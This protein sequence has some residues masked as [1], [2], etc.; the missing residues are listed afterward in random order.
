VSDNP[1]PRL[2]RL[3]GYAALEKFDLNL[4]K[5]AFV[6]CQDYNAIQFIKNISNVAD[7]NMKKAQLL[8]YLNKFDEAENVYT[9]TDNHEMALEMRIKLGDWFKVMAMIEDKEFSTS[10]RLDEY[11]AKAR[12]SIGEYFFEKQRYTQALSYFNLKQILYNEI[13]IDAIS[14]EEIKYIIECLYNS[15]KYKELYDL[16]KL[17]PAASK[18]EDFLHVIGRKLITVGL[19]E[20]GVD[21]LVRSG[22]IREAIDACVYLNE[23]EQAMKLA[24][25]Q[26]LSDEILSFFEKY[27]KHLVESQKYIEAI[28]LYRRANLSTKSAEYLY[29][30]ARE[31]TQEGKQPLLSKKLYVLA[32]IEQQKQK[33]LTEDCWSGAEAYHLFVLAQKQLYYGDYQKSARNS[34]RLYDYLNIIPSK[35]VYA[36]V[37]LTCYYGH[38]YVGCSEAISRLQ[39]GTEATWCRSQQLFETSSPLEEIAIKIF[40]KHEPDSTSNT[41]ESTLLCKQCDSLMKEQDRQCNKCLYVYHICMATGDTILSSNP[42]KEAHKCEQCNHY[43]LIQEYEKRKSCPLCYNSY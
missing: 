10:K 2:W 38:R 34:L 19:C 32:A 35:Q 6:K 17:L 18:Y 24:K 15:E 4:A 37:A 31:S 28:E 22:H 8:T 40:S 12:F 36:L 7:G 1:H 3:L 27:A 41:L 5:Q 25:K 13:S 39:A 26:S 30:L 11:K 20:E 29:K 33:D 9:K 21:S 23:W 16:S 42:Q 14:T 43:V